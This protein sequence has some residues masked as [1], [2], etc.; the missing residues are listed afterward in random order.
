R[1]PSASRDGA[2]LFAKGCSGLPGNTA[3]R[4]LRG[5]PVRKPAGEETSRSSFQNPGPQGSGEY[6]AKV[7]LETGG[8][9]GGS[10]LVA[11]HRQVRAVTMGRFNFPC[12]YCRLA[13]PAVVP[14]A[15]P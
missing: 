15:V 2:R 5:R 1:G 6:G 14:A 3:L 11:S 8:P 10:D 13:F 4:T 7:H 9:G 12:R